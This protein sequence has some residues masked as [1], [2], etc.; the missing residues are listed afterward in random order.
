[1]RNRACGKLLFS[2][3]A[4]HA[5][6]SAAETIKS[7]RDQYPTCER[8]FLVA[9]K[10]GD[11]SLDKLNREFVKKNE[12]GYWIVVPDRVLPDDLMFVVLPTLPTSRFHTSHG[13]PRELFAGVV[14]RSRPDGD[15]TIF[16]VKKFRKLASIDNAI[17]AFLEGKAPPQ[18]NKVLQV[19]GPK[20]ARR[21]KIAGTDGATVPLDG[22]ET[23]HRDLE[24]IGRRLDLKPT[25]REALIQARLGQGTYRKQ[26][27]KLWGG[28][29]AVTGLT[30]QST[31]IA[32]HAKP[33]VDCTDEERLDPCNG[34]PLMATI[35][36]LFDR[37]LIAFAPETGM[38]LI[39]HRVK[40]ADRA[41]LGIPANLRK[42][43]NEQ[44][45]YYLRLHLA[46]FDLHEVR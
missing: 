42:I 33:W 41:I 3:L 20:S 31:L 11:P 22:D 7:Y 18:G 26:M 6:M 27:L 32:S 38:M 34:L 14:T 9:G 21:S 30:I 2:N 16:E 40:K 23:I 1:M 45:A 44:Q 39:S 46:N 8:A 13:Y 15:R 4:F 19:W 37:Y 35:D 17:M 12:T 29:C 28:K 25:Q 24:A 43:P 10:P 5:T 36:R